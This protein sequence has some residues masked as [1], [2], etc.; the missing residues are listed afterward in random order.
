MEFA[1]IIEQFIILFLI[2]SVGYIMRKK[3]L[4]DSELNRGLSDILLDIV[5]PAL[6]ISSMT[7]KINSELINN[8]LAIFLL[9]I[10]VYGLIII[11]S[12]FIAR[13]LGL[14]YRRQ[15]VFRF[16]LI[17]GNVGYMAL[18]VLD[19]IYPDY[20]IYYAVI[21][22]AVFNFIQWTY[23]IYLFQRHGDDVG[24]SWNKLLNNGIIATMIGFFL[25]VTGFR[26]P[27]PVA[28]AVELIGEMTFPLSMIVIG[29]SLAGV[30]AR[31]VIR[32]KY[33]FLLSAFKLIII[34][35]ILFLILRQL[36]LPA[37]VANITVLLIAMPSGANGVLFAERYD[38][39]QT[40]AAECVFLSTLFS[41][42]TLP[43]FITLVKIL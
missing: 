28:G 2:I 12:G 3:G 9:S 36:P 34:P 42:L 25:L 7:R 43:A 22:N 19:I 16:V 39:D 1:S 23:G 40:F 14:P 37:I 17:F 8:S 5:L 15:T 20:G 27:S 33:I 13:R 10:A 29:S 35:G 38:G 30:R 32:D 18:P 21:S 24:V 31:N 4:I 11:F 41:L 6:I 26:F